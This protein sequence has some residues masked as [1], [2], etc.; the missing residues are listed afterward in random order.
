MW[1]PGVIRIGMGPE[2]GG[3]SQLLKKKLKSPIAEKKR[4]C[5]SIVNFLKKFLKTFY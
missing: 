5:F 4:P 3:G 2:V 1:E